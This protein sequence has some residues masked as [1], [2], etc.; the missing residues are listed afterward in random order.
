MSI[1]EAISNDHKMRPMPLFSVHNKIFP[2]LNDQILQ[3]R[4]QNVK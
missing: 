4:Y 1:A 3:M 2:K